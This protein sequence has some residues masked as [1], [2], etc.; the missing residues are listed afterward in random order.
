MFQYDY[1]NDVEQIAQLFDLKPNVIARWS[2]S[3]PKQAHM[4]DNA[5]DAVKGK[6]EAEQELNALRQL[7][8][9]KTINESLGLP[10]AIDKLNWSTIP[11]ITLRK[12]FRSNRPLYVAMLIGLRHIKLQE[13]W[14]DIEPEQTERIRAALSDSDVAAM[15]LSEPVRLTALIGALQK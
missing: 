1:K 13:L 8:D 2:K 7:E 3:L 9:H 5:Y 12:W 11:T 14:N 10:K 6:A 4:L 15:Y